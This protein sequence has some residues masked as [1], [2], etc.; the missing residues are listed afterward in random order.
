MRVRWLSAGQSRICST[1]P[2]APAP[3]VA[4]PPGQDP[5]ARADATAARFARPPGTVEIAL[6]AVAVVVREIGLELRHELLALGL[7]EALP[8]A[9]HDEPGHG[10]EIEALA[11]GGGAIIVGG[12]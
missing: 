7:L 1:L 11:G 12:G 3:P 5:H 10:R 9:S 4:P 6:D 2:A 8:V